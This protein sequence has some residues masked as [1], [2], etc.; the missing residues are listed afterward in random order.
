MDIYYLVRYRASVP[1]RQHKS[2]LFFMILTLIV[3]LFQLFYPKI[4][5]ELFAQSLVYLSLIFTVED[6][7]DLINPVTKI[8]NRKSFIAENNSSLEA[9]IP[10]YLLLVKIINKDS[11][12]NV[13]GFSFLQNALKQI[14]DFLVSITSLRNVYDCDNGNFVIIFYKK[15]HSLIPITTMN[16]LERF[17]K[18]WGNDELSISFEATVTQVEVPV[19]INNIKSIMELVDINYSRD[20][21]GNALVQKD[22]LKILQRQT[23]VEKAIEKAINNKTLQVYFQPIWDCNKNKIICAEA[24]VRLYDDVLGFIPPDEFIP[25][26]EQNGLVSK[27]GEF[28]FEYTCEFFKEKDLK[29]IGIEFIDVNLST[30]QCMQ[31]NIAKRFKI[32][33]DRYGLSPECINLEI[34]ESAAINSPETF[35]QCMQEFRSAGFCF[36]LDDYGTGYSNASYIFNMDFSIIKIDKSILWGAEKNKNAKIILINTIKMIKEM[37]L[38]IIVEGVE[39]EEQKNLVKDLGCDLC[40]GFYFS[41]PVNRI[42]FIEYCKKFNGIQ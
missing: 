21:N 35:L 40:Q 23:S 26:A 14:A 16:I 2:F 41:R 13:I 36:S 12:S 8:F 32:I 7:G 30:V 9:N 1:N 10:Y 33:L 11:Y 22:Y 39:T 20:K 38:K 27:I 18:E 24:L 29:K 19:D 15:E 37:G 42:D 31:K 25:I 17:E 5:I 28:V 3:V 4:L 6:D 34:T